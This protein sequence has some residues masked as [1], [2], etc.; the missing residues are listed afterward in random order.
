[1]L[2]NYIKIAWRNLIRHK[3]YAFIN[4][5]GL[6]FGFAAFWAIA[7]YVADELSF[8]RYNT[9]ANRIVRVVQHAWW[10]GG[11][12]NIALTS[13][14]FAPA[15][16][17]AYP[18]IEDAVRIDPEGGGI[19]TYGNKKIKADDI[20]FADKS[21]LTIFTYNF[22]DGDATTALDNP[23]S[24][25]LNKSLAEKLFGAADKAL[26]QTIYFDNNDGYKVTG[27]IKDIPNN[28]HLRFSAVRSLPINDTG[29][30]QN[31]RIYTYLLL[32]NAGSLGELQK[33]MPQFAAN[34]IQKEMHVKNYQLE[35]QPLT[36]IHL[37]SNLD[38]EI[39]ANGSISRV[40]IFIAIALLILIIAIINYMNLA[41]ARSSSRV[42]EVGVRKAIGSG[43]GNLAGMFITESVLVTIMAAGISVFVVSLL[44]PFFNQLSGKELTIWRFGVFNTLVLLAGFSMITGIVSGIYPSVFL[45]RFKTIPALRGEMENR[46]GHIVLRKSLVVFQFVVTVVMIAGSIIIYQQLQFAARAD[47]GFNK[48]QVLTFHID[49]RNVRDQIPAL[50][51]QL[52]QSPL[53]KSVAAAGNP[54]GNND[55]GSFGYEYEKNDGS[56][57]D[58]TEMA[59]ELMVDPDFLKTMEIKLSN[60]RNFSDAMPSDQFGAILVNETLVKDLGWKNAI[61]KKMLK[62]ADD[63]G[64]T[65][66]RKVIG[67]IKDF[68]TY[69][70]QHKEA[71][72]VMIMPPN[73]KE[74]DNLYIKIAKGKIPEGLAYLNRIYRQFDKTN[75]ITYHFLDRN[76]AKQYAAEV[77]QGEMALIFSI[78]AILIACLG[79]FGLATFTAEQRT[80]EIGIR[81]VL[82][83]RVTDIV[84]ML[85]SDFLKLVLV[86]IIISIPVAWM[87][88]N[89]WLQDFAYRI[90]IEWWVLAAAGLV[91]LTIALMTVSFRTIK[92]AMASPVKSLRTE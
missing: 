21:L 66:P 84:R 85:S 46:L 44:L 11:K 74:E 79:L 56:A 71:P 63:N 57:S 41:T 9:N 69:S 4:I 5:A 47:L 33:K 49:D 90:H 80:K 31:A 19:I 67:V 17:A 20:I 78:L 55:L 72:L 50:K 64:K 45:S 23:Q 62:A 68:H 16:K 28:S 51:T 12:L 7:L 13:P 81:K 22:L 35:L 88:M 60:G 14:P 8:D 32:K 73:T 1:M 25:V 42:R 77:R 65:E 18:E 36:S 58:K 76:F 48:D 89:Q 92:A 15:L 91:A 52:L 27:I 10:N 40:Y 82:G 26:N 39:S 70:L 24:I 87:A 38:Y 29:S 30:W 43:R 2:T 83:A 3:D 59:Q 6:V 54:I 53:I 61:G 86:A 75:P 34:T 37:H